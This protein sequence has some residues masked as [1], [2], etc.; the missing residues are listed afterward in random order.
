MLKRIQQ[1]GRSYAAKIVLSKARVSAAFTAVKRSWR[2]LRRRLAT[3]P[4]ER[5]IIG[6]CMTAGGLGAMILAVVAAHKSPADRHEMVFT[7]AEHGASA[8]IVAAFMGV[9]YELYMLRVRAKHHKHDEE[10]KLRQL[11]PLMPETVLSLL[12]DVATRTKY[13]PT[14]FE[15]CRSDQEVLFVSDPSVFKKLIGATGDRTRVQAILKEWL[16][17]SDVRLRFLASDIV[18]VCELR[19]FRDEL[20]KLADSMIADWNSVHRDHQDWVLNYKWAASRCE[21]PP[22]QSLSKLLHETPHEEIQNWILFV[23]C[24]MPGH[25]LSEMVRLYLKKR[26]PSISYG[27]R[28]RTLEAMTELHNVRSQR[29]TL[30][31]HRNLFQHAELAASYARATEVIERR[32]GQDRRAKQRDTPDRRTSSTPQNAGTQSRAD[33]LQENV[34]PTSSRS[35]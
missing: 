27:N 16:D 30:R 23:P 4:I 6:A 12:G 13:L 10:E 33:I 29:R 22:Y 11:A 2:T 14:L 21:D 17:S 28:Q 5:S 19:E 20:S 15:R 8:L 26:G 32:S 35:A 18:G 9:T 3:R 34:T 24:Q 25:E 31:R 7:V 1:F